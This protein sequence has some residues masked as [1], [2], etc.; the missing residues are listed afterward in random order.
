MS[1]ANLGQQSIDQRSMH[2]IW[3]GIDHVQ[4]AIPIG[5]EDVARKFYVGVL[6]F[7]EVP[8]PASMAARGGAWF[9]SGPTKIHVGA[10]AAFVPARKAHPALR[11]RGLRSFIAEV[12]ID[13]VW[14]D[15]IAGV[16]RCFIDD[17]F[18]NRIELIEVDGGYDDAENSL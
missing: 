1:A 16:D 15:E 7:G 12:G 14:S 18:G 6:R 4:V 17:P 5:G 10:E 2:P 9:E 3:A 11:V 8:K 13:V